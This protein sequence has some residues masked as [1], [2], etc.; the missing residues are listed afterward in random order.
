M[1]ASWMDAAVSKA[2][3]ALDLLILALQN[4]QRK[5]ATPFLHQHH[6]PIVFQLFHLHSA[7]HQ[8]LA[9]PLLSRSGQAQTSF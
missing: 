2:S 3:K 1:A 7:N 4:L 8:F 6:L 5:S 9:V